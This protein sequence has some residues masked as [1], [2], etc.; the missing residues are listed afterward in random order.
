MPRKLGLAS[1]IGLPK[2][3]E[4]QDDLAPLG[5]LSGRS[6]KHELDGAALRAT[7]VRR[8]AGT[9]DRKALTKGAFTLLA[10]PERFELPTA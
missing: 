9:E 4:Y 5:N 7:L 8:I 3:R 2:V 10:R 6:A 1:I